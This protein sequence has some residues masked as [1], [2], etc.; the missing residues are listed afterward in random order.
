[1]YVD[2]TW[3]AAAEIDGG[4]V[5]PTGRQAAMEL[6]K[7]RWLWVEEGEGEIMGQSYRVVC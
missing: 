3:T 1:M 6:A 5:R 2:Q 7:L 4:H